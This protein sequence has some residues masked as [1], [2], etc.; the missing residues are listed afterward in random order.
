MTD[1]PLTPEMQRSLP[2][3][4]MDDATYSAVEDALDSVHAPMQDANGHWL[5]LP[6]RVLALAATLGRQPENAP[7]A[8]P[9]AAAALADAVAAVLLQ[10]Q[11]AAAMNAERIFEEEAKV[12]GTAVEI[13]QRA[14]ARLETERH[15]PVAS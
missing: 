5:T 12:G 15:N 3:G 6:E 8:P 7:S 13:Y 10:R 11:H 1:T 4:R 14:Q 9:Q 2:G